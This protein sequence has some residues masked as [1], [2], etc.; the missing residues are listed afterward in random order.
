[1]LI[2]GSSRSSKTAKEPEKYH[3]EP[4][5]KRKFLKK[6]ID[7]NQQNQNFSNQEFKCTIP[8]LVLYVILLFVIPPIGLYLLWRNKACHKWFPHLLLISGGYWLILSI[9]LLGQFIPILS[10]MIQEFGI[11][12]KTFSS[13][14]Y[15]FVIVFVF[16]IISGFLIDKKTSFAIFT[17]KNYSVI[18]IIFLC[19]DFLIFPIAFGSTLGLTVQKS[20]YEKLGELNS[21]PIETTI[22]ETANWKVYKNDEYGFDIKYPRDW[23]V[24]EDTLAN[25]I[26]FGERGLVTGVG[27][28]KIII[29]KIGFSVGLY[30]NVGEL[31]GNKEEQ[32]SLENWISKTFL[33][34]EAGE[35]K[36]F[37]TFGIGN[38]EGVLVKKFKSV[39]VIRLI[40]RIFVQK[41]SFIYEIK[42]EVPTPATVD[43]PTEYNYEETFGQILSTFRFLE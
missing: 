37:T 4:Y 23:T 22:D 2:I 16:Q 8:R 31:W 19:I 29:E 34:L 1:M 7:M 13:V 12:T 18:A 42:G 30:R 28:E 25:E 14:L 5:F 9:A 33:P 40:T 39:G 10:R 27:G 3:P 15:V 11:E 17:P 38:Y 24:K 20:L 32:L 41:N 6:F 43:V 26:N 21:G 36:E 35:V